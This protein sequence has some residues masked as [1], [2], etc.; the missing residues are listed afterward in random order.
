MKYILCPKCNE[1]GYIQNKKFYHSFI[2]DINCST[3]NTDISN[4]ERDTIISIPNI[5]KLKDFQEDS[6][7]HILNDK[8]PDLIVIPTGEGKTIVGLSVIEKLKQST[9]I[10]CPTIILTKQW[11]RV[12]NEYG[13]RATSISSEGDNIISPITITTYASALLNLNMINQFKIIIFDEAHHVCSSQYSQIAKYAILK[14]IKIVGLTATE[15]YDDDG[16]VIQ[17]EIFKR[18]Y[19][20]T[21]VERQIS[22]Y[23]VDLQF[24]PISIFM[25]TE[26]WDAYEE[27]WKIYTDYM[28]RYGGFKDMKSY[29]PSNQYFYKINEGMI[30]YNRI[31]KLLSEIPQKLDK[32]IEIIKKNNGTFIVF[33]DTIAMADIL[34]K[35]L[36][37]NKISTIKIHTKRSKK[38]VDQTR[39]KREKYLDKVRNGEV[40]VI[41]GVH[42]IEEGLDL[43]D[44]DNAI[45]VSIF[46][47]SILKATQR[48]GRVMRSRPNKLATIY[49]LYCDNTIEEKRLKK[50]KELL[51]VDIK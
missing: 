45:F 15:R 21:I 7:Y 22:Q 38:D 4:I 18:K 31:K 34:Y 50:L 32:V 28:R 20:R 44:I 17:E 19:I 2:I 35:K 9:L 37:L 14:N 26:Q 27:Y 12:I 3:E 5:P 41:V 11:E 30:A 25:T 39:V 13:G 49:V 42:A 6:L 36:I 10:I 29:N 51:A 1:K 33:G 43:P 8:T 46:S 24:I 23:R 47:S 16:K 48:A 40:R